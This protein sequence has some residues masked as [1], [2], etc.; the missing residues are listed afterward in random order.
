M[1]LPSST[2]PCENPS[3][4]VEVGALDTDIGGVEKPTLVE[5]FGATR[6]PGFIPP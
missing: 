2:N 5:K 4:V 6:D 1:P 3:L